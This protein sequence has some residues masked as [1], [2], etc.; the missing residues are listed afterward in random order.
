MAMALTPDTS[1]GGTSVSRLKNFYKQFGCLILAVIFPC[2][3][4]EEN[5]QT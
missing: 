4:A 5:R 1:F 2:F 3:C